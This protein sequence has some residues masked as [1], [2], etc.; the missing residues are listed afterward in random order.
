MN[1][2]K[3]FLIAYFSTASS[4]FAAIEARTVITI[5]SAI[6]L[7]IMFFA[8]GKAIDVLVQVYLDRRRQKH[9]R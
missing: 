1:D 2:I 8:V 9:D 5:L 3:N 4:F 7:P 6:V